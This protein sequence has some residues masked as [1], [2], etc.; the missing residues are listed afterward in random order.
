MNMNKENLTLKEEFKELVV[1]NVD[2][3]YSLAP[4]LEMI[5]AEGLETGAISQLVYTEDIVNF[6]DRHNLAIRD[7][8][9]EIK[10]TMG[11]EHIQEILDNYVEIP[12][13]TVEENLNKTL[14]VYLVCEELAYEELG[15][16]ED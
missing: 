2:E 10:L 12:L 11:V 16:L 13:N 1:R 9:D 5:A 8:V 6:F 3:G 15:N 4:L 7:K 14:L